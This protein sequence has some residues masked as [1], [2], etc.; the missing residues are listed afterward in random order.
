MLVTYICV[1][2][3]NNMRRAHLEPVS[4][5]DGPGSDL[6]LFWDWTL[7]LVG[8]SVNLR[9]I[10]VRTEILAPI[11]SIQGIREF[12]IHLI[13]EKH[14]SNESFRGIIY[15]HLRN[16]G[17]CLTINLKWCWVEA[18]EDFNFLATPVSKDS[19]PYLLVNRSCQEEWL[20][21]QQLKNPP[22]SNPQPSGD[23]HKHF[24]HF[25]I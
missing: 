24:K 14:V 2:H 16:Q 1:S 5:K 19:F 18:K 22:R 7:N 13:P 15:R 21:E 4:W 6:G 20:N 23:E 3:S 10:S 17:D 8:S 12:L 25:F 11:Y 9:R